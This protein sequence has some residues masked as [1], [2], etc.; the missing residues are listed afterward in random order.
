MCRIPPEKDLRANGHLAFVSTGRS[1]AYISPEILDIGFDG[2]LAACGTY[3][4]YAGEE[5]FNRVI[6]VEIVDR[7]IEVFKKY[8]AYPV[9]EGKEWLYFDKIIYPK[10]KSKG[11]LF[12]EIFKD[13]VVPVT[14]NEGKYDVNK[15]TVFCKTQEAVDGLKSELS[16]AFDFIQHEMVYMELVPKGFSKGTGIVE[17]CRRLGI[18]KEDTFAFGDSSNDLEMFEA[19]GTAVCMG[20]GSDDAKEAADYVTGHM[21]EEGLP[22]ALRHFGLIPC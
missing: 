18:A 11:N 10:G 12:D 13:V 4:Y 3:I 6:P 1:R 7:S 8:G 16:D 22:D 19:V 20:N 5:L 17:I 9:L 21:E 2:V 14:G 15:I